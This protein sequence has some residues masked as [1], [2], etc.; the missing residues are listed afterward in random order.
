MGRLAGMSEAGHNHGD[1][2]LCDAALSR[3]F[4]FLGK[5]W[6]GVLLA[7]LVGGPLGF[8]Q[9]KRAVAGISDSVLSERLA[10]L[11]HAGLVERTVKEGPPVTV[12][13]ALTANGQ[14]L[15]PALQ[16]L[17]RWAAQNLT[18]ERCAEAA[19][20]AAAPPRTRVS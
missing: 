3:A 13:Y 11:A 19:R 18:P 1:E 8:S 12:S 4:Q 10:E 16:E 5:R 6:N 14:A 7:T 17:T 15:T 2:P 20:Q 9:L